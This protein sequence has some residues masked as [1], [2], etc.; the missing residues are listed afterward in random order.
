MGNLAWRIQFLFLFLFLCTISVEGFPF[1]ASSNHTTTFGD[2][3]GN[4]QVYCE[5]TTWYDICWFV[6]TNYVLHALSVRSLAGENAYTST[7]FK[8]CCLLVPYTGLRRGLCLISRASNL[9]GNDLQGAAR[10]NALCMVIRNRDWTPRDGDRIDGCQ[11]DFN[12]ADSR[13]VP[14][15]L[16]DKDG[17]KKTEVVELVRTADLESPTVQERSVEVGSYC[18]DSKEQE[19][20]NRNNASNCLMI[21]VKDL[22]QHSPCLG[23]FD[24][25]SRV[26]TETSRLGNYPPSNSIVDHQNVKIQGLCEMPAGYALSYVPGDIKV[27][28]RYHALVAENSS[29]ETKQSPSQTRIASAKDFPRILFS[30]TQ[31]ISGGYALFKAQGSQIERY[32]FAA[33]GLTVVPYIV[34]SIIN[35]VGALLTS[36]YETVFLVH[37]SIMDEMISR[38]GIVDGVV[39]TIDIPT[40]NGHESPLSKGEKIIELQ[41]ESMKFNYHDD[42]LYCRSFETRPSTGQIYAV[43]PYEPSKPKLKPKRKFRAPNWCDVFF[44]ALSPR[45]PVENS[46]SPNITVPS[47]SSFTLLPRPRSQTGLN[48]LCMVLS[49]ITISAPYIV[50]SVLTGWKANESSSVQRNFTL[51]WLICGQVHGY[52]AANVEHLSGKR[53]ALK[54]L[55]FAFICYGSY[56]V[57]G[58]YVVAQEMLQFGTC[59]AV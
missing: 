10:A 44:R 22:Y 59:T 28:Q 34:I 53:N 40:E 23:I 6:F 38:G 26:M 54:G 25:A 33:F 42:E 20:A 45:K 51:S 56:C 57:S 14:K 48:L 31:T 55:L 15:A 2:G 32:G 5:P 52:V 49:L 16:S 27:Y 29:N 7:V 3:S 12:R 46:A 1:S 47:H 35:F 37:S 4:S 30:L 39:G 17:V 19:K 8:L 43:L 11:V 18:S 24:K 13:N 41:G 9:A 50:I 21:K 58:F 36:E